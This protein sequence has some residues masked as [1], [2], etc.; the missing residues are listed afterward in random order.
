M[1]STEVIKSYS[2]PDRV[3]L[4]TVTDVMKPVHKAVD[5]RSSALT[6][7]SRHQ[8]RVV[9]VPGDV[10]LREAIDSLTRRHLSSHI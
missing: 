9:P 5:R 10:G 2:P 6:S 1:T 7:W 8:G 3:S 4:A